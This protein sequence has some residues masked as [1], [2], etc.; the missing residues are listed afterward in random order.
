LRF[1]DV[2]VI[3]IKPSVYLAVFSAVDS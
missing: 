2:S 1:V 3:C